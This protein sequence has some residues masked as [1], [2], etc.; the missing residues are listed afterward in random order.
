MQSG[1]PW[2]ITLGI[3]LASFV[4]EDGATLFAAGLAA[5]H[6]LDLKL[7][8]A[9]A[10]AGVWV[11]DMGLYALA[12]GLGGTATHS[13]WFTRIFTET[14][15]AR[16]EMWAS[17]NG[18]F[19]LAVSRFLPGTRFLA[20]TGAGLLRFPATL[21][22]AITAATASVWV[23]LVFFGLQLLAMHKLKALQGLSPIGAA[24]VLAGG[25]VAGLASARFVLIPGAKWVWRLIRK[26]SQWEFWPA[27]LFY[28]PIAL[29]CVRLATKYR[30]L[31]LPTAANPGF[32]NGGVVGE[33]KS[34]ALSHLALTS[35]EFTA[36][37][38]VIPPDE[39]WRRCRYWELLLNRN[40]V[41][42]PFIFKP[43][44]GQ[45]GA[46]FKVI[47]VCREAR[48]Y[49]ARVQAPVV[50][51]RYIPGP[52]EIG[53]FYYRLPGTERGEIFGITEKAFPKIVGDGVH[54][55]EQLLERDLRAS[56]IAGTYEKRFPELKGVV[57]EAGREVRLVEAGNHCQGCIF[58]DGWHLYSEA[59]RARI[60]A[61]SQGVPGFYVGRYDI[62]YESEE[63]LRDGLG[64]RIIE[65]NGAASEA[66]NV[67]DARNSL[68]AA[69]RTL[70]RQWELVF[71]IGAMNRERGARTASALGI[72][73]EWLQYQR[74]ALSY[75][76]AD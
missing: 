16:A 11:G 1:S 13:A 44:V 24:S 38:W 51:Q 63:Q 52:H 49:L 39:Q 42:Y 7:A 67:Y 53:I 20:F 10:F 36:E 4:S 75:P 30:G 72:L 56:V 45:R 17:R 59:L 27:W 37:S 12:R 3:A 55:F 76:D 69:Y 50:M 21:F 8:L 41:E 62:R 64:F 19:A 74:V 22:A 65:L 23:G 34:E 35:P 47:R 57:L 70:Y 61:I 33:S 32:H 26:Y 6:A 25:V 40:Q 48:A 71:R 9:G 73:R 14:R 46:G 2:L 18:A 54:T 15:R 28:P 66:T 68:M 31:A 43:D 29:M 5:Q 60:D 58:R